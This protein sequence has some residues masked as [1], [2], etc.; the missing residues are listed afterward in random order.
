MC[1]YLNRSSNIHDLF[2]VATLDVR[3]EYHSCLLSGNHLLVVQTFFGTL[4]AAACIQELLDLPVHSWETRITRVLLQHCRMLRRRNTTW[5]AYGG[6]VDW[7]ADA[8]IWTSCNVVA[9]LT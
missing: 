6:G 4:S 8:A 1:R 2:A 9:A 3:S 7:F 5:N